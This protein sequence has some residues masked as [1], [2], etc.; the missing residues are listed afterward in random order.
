[1]TEQIY[2]SCD[3][4]HK[5]LYKIIFSVAGTN[6]TYLVCDNCAAFD[7]FLKYVIKKEKISSKFVTNVVK[8][9]G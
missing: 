9:N 6:K 7:Y 1:M 2:F 5:F 8:S 3:E 4:E